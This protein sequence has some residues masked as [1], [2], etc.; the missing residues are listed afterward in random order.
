MIIFAKVTGYIFWG[1][2]DFRQSRGLWRAQSEACVSDK[3]IILINGSRSDQTGYPLQTRQGTALS[4]VLARNESGIYATKTCASRTNSSRT[5]APWTRAS[6][7][8]VPRTYA[9]RARV[10]DS[11]MQ[12]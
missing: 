6:K 11:C 8:P 3:L 5:N 4:Q 2:V 10:Q 7:T 9:F 12:G 1:G